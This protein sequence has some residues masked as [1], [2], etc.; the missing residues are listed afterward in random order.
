MKPTIH[1]ELRDIYGGD[2]IT[3]TVKVKQEKL[4]RTRKNSQV[5]ADIGVSV[6]DDEIEETHTEVRDNKIKTFRID[7][8]KPVLRIG[9]PHGKIWGALKD[10]ASQLRLL[11][12]KPFTSGYKSFMNMISVQP[13]WATLELNGSKI[14]TTTLPQKLPTGGMIFE[15]YDV[16][17]KC[18]IIF[19]LEF[20]DAYEETATLLLDRLQ[21]TAF[22][23]KRRASLKITKIERY[24]TKIT[25]PIITPDQPGP[26]QH[27]PFQAPPVQAY[28]APTGPDHTR[29]DQ[30]K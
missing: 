11:G 10:C 8:N 30:T 18:N 16:I 13:V 5:R 15:Q 28:P 23:N 26:G 14:E 7:N 17:P 19:E 4:K 27:K 21:K 25:N 2:G 1:G 24:A 20:P 29:P 12:V 22:L 3:R 6:S 9:G